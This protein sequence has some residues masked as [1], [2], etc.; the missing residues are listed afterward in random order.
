VSF[1][2]SV[3]KTADTGSVSIK[4]IDSFMSGRTKIASQRR[5]LAF[6]WLNFYTAVKHLLS[7]S[8]EHIVP[9]SYVR[10]VD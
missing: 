2:S 3:V 6:Y 5:F 1:R 10:T 7:S 8:T 4:S 9:Y